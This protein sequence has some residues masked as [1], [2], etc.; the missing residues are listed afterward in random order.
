M[1][2]IGISFPSAFGNIA[3]TLLAPADVD[4]VLTG[5]PVQQVPRE[6]RA[7]VALLLRDGILHLPGG[8]IDW[9]ATVTRGQALEILAR[10]VSSRVQPSNIKSQ[11]TLFSFDTAAGAQ[12]GRLVIA[13]LP[14]STNESALRA[15]GSRYATTNTSSSVTRQVPDKSRDVKPVTSTASDAASRTKDDDNPSALEIA[16][17]AWLFR[18]LGDAS[19]AVDRLSLAGGERVTYHLN[20][21][22]QVDFLEASV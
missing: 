19:Y 21:D 12:K 4:Y 18:K 15:T 13:K 14:S 17:D 1:A 11:T 8:M 10:V 5:L 20:K 9:R 16:E 3:T 6:A 7:E 22:G 2:S